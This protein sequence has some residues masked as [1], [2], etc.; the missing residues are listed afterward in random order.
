MTTTKMGDHNWKQFNW[1]LLDPV[2]NH[3]CFHYSFDTDD[4]IFSFIIT[5]VTSP[6]IP[7][8]SVGERLA[9][10]LGREEIGE[11]EEDPAD[12]TTIYHEPWLARKGSYDCMHH[13]ENIP[14]KSRGLLPDSNRWENMK[15]LNLFTK[16]EPYF[17]FHEIICQSLHKT[18]VFYDK[19]I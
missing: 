12:C 19:V 3:T 11:V 9:I 2:T 1:L 15:L 18:F 5:V 17:T 13:Y 10:S 6:L 4:L 16:I 14:A 7:S 8:R